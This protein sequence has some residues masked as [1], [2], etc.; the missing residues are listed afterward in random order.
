MGMIPTRSY[1]AVTP[2][3]R[4]ARLAR[5]LR[6]HRDYTGWTA[7]ATTDQ[8]VPAGTEGRVLASKR[9]SDGLVYVLEFPSLNLHTPLPRSGIELIKPQTSR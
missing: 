8:D 9:R 4:W 1:Y 5:L 3:A 6:R 2:P 7:R